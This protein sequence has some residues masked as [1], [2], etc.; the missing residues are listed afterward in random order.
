VK[1]FWPICPAEA[2]QAVPAANK[3]QKNNLK[4]IFIYLYQKTCLTACLQKT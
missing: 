2:P 4:I 1:D 3:K